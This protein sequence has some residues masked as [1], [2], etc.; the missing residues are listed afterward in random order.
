MKDTNKNG[1]VSRRMCISVDRTKLCDGRYRVGIYTGQI[2]PVAKLPHGQGTMQYFH[3]YHHQRHHNHHHHPTHTH[4]HTHNENHLLHSYEGSWYDGIWNG[5]ALLTYTSCCDD[6]PE[7]EE[8]EGRTAT[9]TYEGPFLD[10]HKHGLFVVRYDDGRAYDGSYRMD[11]IQ[12]GRMDIPNVGRYYGDFDRHDR[13]H[14]RGK[15]VFEDGRQYD[16]EFRHG[17]IDGHGRMVY[18]NLFVNENE[19]VSS[20]IDST[21]SFDSDSD[22]DSDC[23]SDSDSDM[24]PLDNIGRS[25]WS[26]N[27]TMTATANNSKNLA[28]VSRNNTNSNTSSLAEQAAY[29]FYLGSFSNGKRYG[30]GVLMIDEEIIHDGHWYDDEPSPSS[31]SSSSPAGNTQRWCLGRIPSSIRPNSRFSATKNKKKDKKKNNNKARKANG[32]I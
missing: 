1:R 20:D 4:T 6:P 13:P 31:S 16:G 29:S 11:Q 5:Y 22:S 27:S 17:Q 30:K 7:E 12:R 18:G 23:D 26:L 28:I 19:S 14:G 3:C 8:G 21:S 10:G 15:L 32:Q 24:D 25:S 9:T 2:D